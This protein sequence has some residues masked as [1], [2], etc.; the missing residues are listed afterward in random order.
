MLVFLFENMPYIT[1]GYVML[2]LIV[3][4]MIPLLYI[5]KDRKPKRLTKYK[6]KIITFIFTYLLGIMSI[7]CTTVLIPYAE[8]LLNGNNAYPYLMVAIVAVLLIVYVLL[9]YTIITTV[10][11]TRYRYIKKSLSR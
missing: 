4:V 11:K 6:R 9:F 1:V 8:W 10:S 7:G 3:A 5:K 2:S